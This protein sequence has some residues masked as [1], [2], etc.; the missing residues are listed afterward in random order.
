MISIN[1]DEIIF[2]F[3]CSYLIDVYDCFWFKNLI[4][5]VLGYRNFFVIMLN[6][7]MGDFIFF[8]D[9]VFERV[10][11]MVI[12]WLKGIN[13][14]IFFN[15]S[16][17]GNYVVFLWFVELILDDGWWIFEVGVDGIWLVLIL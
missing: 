1:W 2:L 5:N 10:L 4:L 12:D 16:E 6:V 17:D 15:V 13:V 11:N 8:L 14:L 7:I 9:N 3:M